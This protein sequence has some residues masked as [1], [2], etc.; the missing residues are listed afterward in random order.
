MIIESTPRFPVEIL[1]IF[2]LERRLIMFPVHH[3]DYI[4]AGRDTAIIRQTS[5]SRNRMDRSGVE[6][7]PI[8]VANLIQYGA[9]HLVQN[10]GPNLP[11]LIV[12]ANVA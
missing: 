8:G 11:G 1:M 6:T 12:C 2:S 7:E 5:M 9:H 4:F 10:L 3:I